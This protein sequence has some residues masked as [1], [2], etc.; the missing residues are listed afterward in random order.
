VTLFYLQ[1]RLDKEVDFIPNYPHLYVCGEPCPI[2]FAKPLHEYVKGQKAEDFG[3]KDDET[4]DG[5]D[6]EDKGDLKQMAF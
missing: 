5:K 3:G 2:G 1:L 4:E 6:A